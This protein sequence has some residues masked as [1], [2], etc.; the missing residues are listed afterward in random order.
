MGEQ[1][2]TA[3][4]EKFKYIPQSRRKL[5]FLPNGQLCNEA[6]ARYV[7]GTRYGGDKYENY[8]WQRRFELEEKREEEEKRRREE[9]LRLQRGAAKQVEETRG[10]NFVS[11]WSH[12]YEIQT[13]TAEEET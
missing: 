5:I 13:G 2:R 11:T 8:Q 10:W 4:V 12:G 3:K 7:Y 1:R 6:K 9:R